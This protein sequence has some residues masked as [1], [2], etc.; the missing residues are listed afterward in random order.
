MPLSDTALRNLWNRLDQLR[1]I[2]AQ[3]EK[4]LAAAETAG[5]TK[6]ET[7]TIRAEITRL[8][9]ER[10]KINAR[11]AADAQESRGQEP[12]GGTT[13]TT[14][15][16]TINV[17]ATGGSM[18]SLAEDRAAL[19]STV[20]NARQA[21][22]KLAGVIADLERAVQ[23]TAVAEGF[24]NHDLAQAV[25]QIRDAKDKADDLAGQVRQGTEGVEKFVAR[26]SG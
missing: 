19:Q 5:R 14:T 13:P 25:A 6:A 24:D 22:E 9:K 17:P 15:T 2:I 3:A 11:L 26:M 8:K 4:N 7:R 10:D 1:S 16:R 18:S 20:E 21:A 12:P 23:G